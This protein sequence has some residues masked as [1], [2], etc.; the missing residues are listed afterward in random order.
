MNPLLLLVL[1]ILSNVDQKDSNTR[2][3]D[4]EYKSTAIIKLPDRYLT[5]QR[6]KMRTETIFK[7]ETLKNEL[8]ILL[9]QRDITI[10]SMLTFPFV[11]PR[12]QME[13]MLIF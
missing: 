3:I 7:N 10:I 1:L 11:V 6:T 5:A 9:H 13:P 12:K 4:L 2:I 8:S